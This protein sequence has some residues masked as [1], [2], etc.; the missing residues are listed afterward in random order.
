MVLAA[1]FLV[2]LERRLWVFEGRGGRP[3]SVPTQGQ[4]QRLLGE[5]RLDQR[6]VQARHAATVQHQDLIPG[7][8]TLSQRQ[9]GFSKDVVNV[10]PYVRLELK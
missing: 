7:T 10:L 4:L 3:G 9:A 2:V 8:Q 6:Q 1:D 5:Q